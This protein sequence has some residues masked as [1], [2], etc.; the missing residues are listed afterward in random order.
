MSYL[1]IRNLGKAFNGNQVVEDVNIELDKGSFLSLLGPSGCGKTTTLRMIAGFI[2]PDTGHIEIDGKPINNLPIYKRNI[3]MVFQ[4]YALFPHM[5]VEENIAYGLEQRKMPRDQIKREV[6]EALEMVRL[7]GFER[8]KP[9]ELSGGQ[10]QRVALARALVIKPSL[11]LLD[12][13]LSALDKRLRVEMQVELRDIQCKV[14]ITTIFV[15]HDQ[16][17][18]MT[19]SDQIVVMKDG[20]IMQMDTPERIYEH[21]ANS[22]VAGFLGEANFFH[23]TLLETNKEYSALSLDNGHTLS[24]RCERELNNNQRY[25][26]AIRPEKIQISKEPVSPLHIKGTITFITYV[27][28]LS[29]FR[30]DALGQEVKVQI[31]NSDK[32]LPFALGEEVYL[33]WNPQNLM[34][35]DK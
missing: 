22:F 15:T 8:R 16:E 1:S 18:A 25:T 19:M 9:K 30:I 3:G 32:N 7:K 13:S 23:G 6:A 31:Q 33:T 34:V 28:N 12:E 20:K 2:A 26:L 11:L 27:G 29:T 4:N 17:E 21:P 5:T 24:F 10:Q 35:L 14:G